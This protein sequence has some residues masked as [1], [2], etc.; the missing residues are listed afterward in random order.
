[1]KLF[2]S[3]ELGLITLYP[4]LGLAGPGS[5]F[6][7]FPFFNLCT[8]QGIVCIRAAAAEQSNPSIMNEQTSSC[9]H[10]T[11]LGDLTTDYSCGIPQ[12]GKATQTY[13]H[14]GNGLVTVYW[15]HLESNPWSLPMLLL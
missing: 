2:T 15:S 1:M 4:V 3:Q 11:H 7:S 14:F 8:Q 10:L 5:F 12:C 13:C 9:Q 6:F